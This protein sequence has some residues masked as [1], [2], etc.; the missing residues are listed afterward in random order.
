LP[1]GPT[2]RV[3]GGS[4]K[5]TV[6]QVDDVVKICQIQ[7]YASDVTGALFFIYNTFKQKVFGYIKSQP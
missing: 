5:I 3:L 1:A 4:F 7:D 2:S 6:L